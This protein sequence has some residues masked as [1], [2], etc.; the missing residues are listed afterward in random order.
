MLFAKMSYIKTSDHGCA[1]HASD[2]NSGR[3]TLRMVASPGTADHPQLADIHKRAN[4][5][6]SDYL[7]H[8]S[9]VTTNGYMGSHHAHFEHGPS[10]AMLPDMMTQSNLTMRVEHRDAGDNVVCAQVPASTLT[11]VLRDGVATVEAPM[12]RGSFRLHSGKAGHVTGVE[13]MP[14]DQN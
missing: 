2:N 8:T 11:A 3:M 5:V 14:P 7:P 6:Q 12:N 1:C 13:F 4:E 9:E 10:H